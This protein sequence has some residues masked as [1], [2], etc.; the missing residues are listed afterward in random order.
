MREHI[1]LEE[2]NEKANRMGKGL[3]FGVVVLGKVP[4]MR[5]ERGGKDEW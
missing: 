4:R 5:R 2:N 3:S 1:L